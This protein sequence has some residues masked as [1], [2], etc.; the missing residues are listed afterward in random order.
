MLSLLTLVGA[1]SMDQDEQSESLGVWF[2]R[3]RDSLLDSFLGTQGVAEL[4]DWQA[5][6]LD[7]PL[8]M[9]VNSLLQLPP[10]AG[11]TLLAQW[12]MLEQLA[13]YPAGRIIF[14]VPLR[15]LAVQ[16]TSDVAKVLA[17]FNDA[18]GT[19]FKVS[20]AEG[21]GAVV[22]LI[23]NNVIV[24]TYEHAAGELRKDPTQATQKRFVSLVVVDEVHNIAKGDR[25]MI[26]D[27]ILFF[28]TLRAQQNA[29]RWQ[30][31]YAQRY[32]G[33]E[34][35]EPPNRPAV[36][37]MSGTLPDWVCSR[38]VESYTDM[39]RTVY[40][41][42]NLGI[43]QAAKP[44]AARLL[45]P[46]PKFGIAETV[47]LVRDF[48]R[49][50]LLERFE[51]PPSEWRR[52]VVFL[53]SVAEAELAFAFM[54]TDPE[55]L[56][57]VDSLAETGQYDAPQIKLV[58]STK[59][60]AK[61]FN[62][63][64]KGEQL[65]VTAKG[66]ELAHRL[67]AGGV[68]I[69][70][71]Q[72]AGERKTETNGG[73]SDRIQAQLAHKDFVAV[74]STSTLSV[75]INLNSTQLGVL[76]PNTMWTIDQAEQMIGR[77]G[78]VDRDTSRSFVCIVDSPL[79]E[80]PG[81]SSICVP[82]TW[83]VPR[84]AAALEFTA[85]GIRDGLPS[86]AN[87]DIRGFFR[88]SDCANLYIP[89]RPGCGV[90]PLAVRWGL[91][92]EGGITRLAKF[93]LDLCKQDLKSLPATV[94]LLQ[95]ARSTQADNEANNPN[96]KPRLSWTMVLL[97][98]VLV[99]RLPGSWAKAFSKANEAKLSETS[100]LPPVP[101]SSTLARSLVGSYGDAHEAYPGDPGTA[102]ASNAD[103]V[104]GF[105]SHLFWCLALRPSAWYTGDPADLLD[106]SLG[107]A[108]F[109]NNLVVD[110]HSL[111][112]AS[113]DLGVSVETVVRAFTKARD[114]LRETCVSYRGGPP[115]AATW[116]LTAEV[117]DA[118]TASYSATMHSAFSA[119][120]LDT[121]GWATDEQPEARPAA[122]PRLGSQ[123]SYQPR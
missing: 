57:A 108:V 104:L 7:Q 95:T 64:H 71:A 102:G 116:G 29:A 90:L 15:V 106:Y 103:K 36:L 35:P 12:I 38:L 123:P 97:W 69:H 45:L 27:D 49:A 25:G 101:R 1:F 122:R 74:F 16:L 20:L 13:A 55:I 42:D 99:C 2:D 113:L 43:S 82:D 44:K 9:Q 80:A 40:T 34:P 46:A 93:A 92:D 89:D 87:L 120:L 19:D 14:A 77:V 81:V 105:F 79:Y 37:G 118:D 85:N 66:P 63:N 119:L 65:Q 11:K 100:F 117:S 76:G 60:L 114:F 91:L 33:A 68:Y 41:P 52:L 18:A 3:N 17:M 73:W 67:M 121:A 47:L 72:L 109:L 5:A 23:T 8:E 10:G 58:N 96:P 59:A 61:K 56:R 39:F 83:F 86:Q 54:S 111:V 28:A 24:A 75:G 21:P 6:F 22:N 107:V 112:S 78:R 88:P 51:K 115:V 4:R 50:L 70:H 98:A 48:V 110:I 31:R 84:L 32:P 62:D 26:I 94:Q 30:A 53:S